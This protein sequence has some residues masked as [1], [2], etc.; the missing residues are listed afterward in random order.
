MNT[1]F[2]VYGLFNDLTHELVYIGS[3]ANPAKRL[4]CHKV[5]FVRSFKDHC[6]MEILEVADRG[7]RQMLESF[8]IHSMKALGCNLMN[9]HNMVEWYKDFIG[10]PPRSSASLKASENYRRKQFYR[11]M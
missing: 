1:P 2:F 3:T 11:N 4:M 7:N 9:K 10:R 5:K 8:W 6:R